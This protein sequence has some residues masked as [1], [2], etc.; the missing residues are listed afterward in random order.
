MSPTDALT[1]D[2]PVEATVYSPDRG[3]SSESARL[4]IERADEGIVMVVQVKPPAGDPRFLGAL[5]RYVELLQTRIEALAGQ[6]WTLERLLDAFTPQQ[7]PPAPA[8]LLQT[9]RN[10]EARKQLLDEFGALRS[11][12]IA[13]MAGSKA[14]N[15]SAT[16]NRW[17]HEK[18]IFAV[19]FHDT[20]YYPG[21]QFGDDGQPLPVIQ[22]VLEVFAQ[23][24]LSDW[25]IAL[26]FST[27]TSAMRDR[28]PVDVLRQD[29]DDVIEAA[30]REVALVSG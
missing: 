11:G 17:R 20:D 23:K 18:R 29:P 9:R 8:A 14:E 15:R 6:R 2:A 21:Y 5:E 28:R 16:A 22:D 30:R 13:D 24:D 12:D 1:R 19:R 3:E 26:W 27:P 7:V 4:L 25:E 10:V